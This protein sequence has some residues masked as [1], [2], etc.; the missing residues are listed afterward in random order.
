MM[1]DA[2]IESVYRDGQGMMEFARKIEALVLASPEVDA[3]RRE[4]AAHG[5]SPGNC[6]VM[7]A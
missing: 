3:M 7:E 4:L 5:C 1:T 2:Q 6:V